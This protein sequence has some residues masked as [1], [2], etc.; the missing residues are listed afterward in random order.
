MSQAIQ[1]ELAVL[2]REEPRARLAARLDR[3]RAL[4]RP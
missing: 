1:H 4:G 2:A 3:Y